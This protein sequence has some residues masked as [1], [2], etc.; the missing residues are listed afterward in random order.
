MMTDQQYKAPENLF[1]VVHAIAPDLER[2]DVHEVYRDTASG[3]S[4]LMV[5][6]RHE[7]PFWTGDPMPQVV[8]PFLWDYP[9]AP[10]SCC[11]MWSTD[12]VEE[13]RGN[14]ESVA[15]WRAAYTVAVPTPQQNGEAA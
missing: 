15:I 6:T 10:M 8:C 3:M 5:V 7:T 12:P 2:V 14:G 4:V 13:E 1:E 9:G 11:F